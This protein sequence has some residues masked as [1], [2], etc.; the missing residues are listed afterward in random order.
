MSLFQTILDSIE[1]PNHVGSQQ[2]LQSVAS[3][4]QLIPGGHEAQQKVR[5]EVPY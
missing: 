5:T 3:L 2:D 1:N 4:A